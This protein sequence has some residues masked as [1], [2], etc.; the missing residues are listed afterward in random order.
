[1]SVRWWL[2]GFVG[3][4]IGLAT[5]TWASTE[6]RFVCVDYINADGECFS[7]ST[8]LFL[9]PYVVASALAVLAVVAVG[10][11]W[12]ARRPREHLAR[13]LVVGSASASMF[14]GMLALVRNGFV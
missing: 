2:A 8:Q 7:K 12:L 4:L 5:A 1:M 10:D 6:E 9:T 11:W 3:S 14:V 13:R